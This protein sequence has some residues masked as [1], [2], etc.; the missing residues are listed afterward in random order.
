MNWLKKCLTKNGLPCGLNFFTVL[1]SFIITWVPLWAAQAPKIEPKPVSDPMLS[2]GIGEYRPVLSGATEREAYL[3]PVSK[4][5]TW[6]EQTALAGS[7][8]LEKISPP[9]HGFLAKQ[10]NY[11]GLPIKSGEAVADDAL[12]EARRRVERLLKANPVI[13]KNLLVIGAEVQVIGKDQV[14]SDLPYQRYWRGKLYDG[15]NDIDKRTRGVGDLF[16]SCG[17][18]NLLKLP[19]DRYLGRDICSHE[20]THTIHLYGLSPNVFAEIEQQYQKT[21]AKG[22]WKG[23]YAASDSMEYLAEMVMWYLGGRGDWPLRQFPMKSG[24]EWLRSYDPEGFDLIDRLVKG[25]LDVKPMAYEVVAP[26]T[27]SGEDE[28]SRWAGDSSKFAAIV[29]ENQTDQPWLCCH[30][31]KEGKRVVANQVLP[32]DQLGVDTHMG[33]GWVVVNPQNDQILASYF[34][35]RDHCKVIIRK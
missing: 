11:E 10:I 35:G 13:L 22:L 32:H 19:N 5:V 9:Q 16:A 21:M 27:L 18:E 6:I 2:Q 17:E 29:F 12:W 14:T 26:L 34:A 4:E 33:A 28:V 15:K 1:L 30:F 31:D 3:V 23:C 7:N 8:S 24:P 25:K 20:F